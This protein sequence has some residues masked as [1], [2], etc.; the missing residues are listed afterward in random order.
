[1]D[2]GKVLDIVSKYGPVPVGVV[3][4]IMVDRLSM[5]Y[6]F[7]STEDEKKSLRD[8]IRDLHAI[9]KSKDD[10]I[11]KLHDQIGEKKSGEKK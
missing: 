4:G 8:Q 2:W 3:L 9:I 10:R 1:M 6:Y 11:D 5:R 7:K